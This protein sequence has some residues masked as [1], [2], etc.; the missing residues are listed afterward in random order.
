MLE[1]TQELGNNVA[2]EVS[3]NGTI[4]ELPKKS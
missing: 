4:R 1:E 3:H 2:E